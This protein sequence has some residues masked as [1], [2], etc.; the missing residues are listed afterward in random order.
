VLKPA[1]ERV[2][3]DEPGRSSGQP[4]V[5][6]RQLLELVDL[7]VE[8]R[9][10]GLHL[11]G[12]A[13]VAD[14]EEDRLGALDQLARLPPVGEDLVLDVA[15]GGQQAAKQRVLLDDARVV[16]DRTHGRD[17]RRQ[18]VDVGGPAR[19]FQLTRA[20]QV[21]ADGESVDRLRLRL[22]LQADHRPEDQLVPGTVEVLRP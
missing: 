12:A 11:G 10:D 7:L 9:L 15:R 6:A 5:L 4:D 21:L 17:Q 16:E 20:A 19:L 2:K 13:V 22:L 8:H 18:G 3:I 1:G 14:L